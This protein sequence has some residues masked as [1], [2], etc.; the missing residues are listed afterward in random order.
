M[1]SWVGSVWLPLR[2]P[3]AWVQAQPP[4]LIAPQDLLGKAMTSKSAAPLPKLPFSLDDFMGHSWGITRQILDHHQDTSV[5]F[6]G[7]C[8]I[9]GGWYHETGQLILAHSPALTSSRRYRWHPGAGG[10]ID[11]FFEDDRFFHHIDL[12]QSSPTAHHLCPPDEYHVTYDFARWPDWTADWQVTGPRK[13]YD[14]RSCYRK[15]HR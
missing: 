11:I 13:S 8:R 7:Q 2:L 3:R 4:G 12:A 14:M 5:Q 10:G 15:T 9:A 6:K 1:A